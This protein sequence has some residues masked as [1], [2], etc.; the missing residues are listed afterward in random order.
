M[1]EADNGV[2]VTFFF[3]STPNVRFQKIEPLKLWLIESLLT[4]FLDEFL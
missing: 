3:K 2:L 4:L 1:V